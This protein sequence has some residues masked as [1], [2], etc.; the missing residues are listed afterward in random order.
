MSVA[1]YQDGPKGTVHRRQAAGFG[2][3]GKRVSS[4]EP[5]DSQAAAGSSDEVGNLFVKIIFRPVGFRNLI[6]NLVAKLQH[7]HMVWRGLAFEL[8]PVPLALAAKGG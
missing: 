2:I 4:G 7:F 5:E 8:Q 1:L 3:M 6:A